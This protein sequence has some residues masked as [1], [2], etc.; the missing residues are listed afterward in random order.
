MAG[1]RWVGRVTR[2]AIAVRRQVHPAYKA[3]AVQKKLQ[4]IPAQLTQK[5]FKSSEN[6]QKMSEGF[7]LCRSLACAM[8]SLWYL[9]AVTPISILRH[10]IALVFKSRDTDFDSL[11]KVPT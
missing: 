5:E 9:R 4:T 7:E 11:T 8:R 2:N 1:E 3:L 6:L 10:E